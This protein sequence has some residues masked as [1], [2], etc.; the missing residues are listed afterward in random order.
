MTVLKHG[1]DLSEH[2]KAVKEKEESDK[3]TS[4]C[5][6]EILEVLKK[7]NCELDAIMII[8]RN[9]VIPQITIVANKSK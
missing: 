6:V 9:G 1:K 7:H 3:R 8:G 4:V 2:L 5:N